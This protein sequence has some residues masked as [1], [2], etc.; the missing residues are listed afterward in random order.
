MPQWCSG[1]DS[2]QSSAINTNIPGGCM[3][4]KEAIRDNGEQQKLFIPETRQEVSLLKEAIRWG[5]IST[6]DIGHPKQ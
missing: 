3:K 5:I 1:N 2:G 6:K 4:T